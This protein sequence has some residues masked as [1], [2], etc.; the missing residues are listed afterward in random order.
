MA[1][2]FRQ[3]YDIDSGTYTYLLADEATGE[4]AIIDPVYERHERDLALIHELQ[5]KLRWSIETHCHADHVT[6]A[7]VISSRTGCKT[8][9]SVASE[10]RGLDHSLQHEDTLDFGS[11]TLEIRATPGH[12]AGCISLI[13]R[14]PNMVFTGDALLIRG[15]GRTD[16]QQ[17]SAEL[18][19]DSICNQLFSLPD[20]TTV[21]PGHDYAGRTSSTIGE[22]RRLNPRIGGGA[23][24]TDFI[25]YLNNMRLPHPRNMDIAVP[26]NLNLGMPDEMPRTPGWAPVTTTYAGVLEVPAQWVAAHLDE[27][28][29]LDVRTVIETD[30]EPTRIA[31]ACM[32]PL[33]ELRDR[34]GELPD[35]GR[36]VMTICRSGRRSVM[37]AEI[38]RGHGRDKVANVKG[39]LLAWY[40]EGLPVERA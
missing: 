1:T 23:N 18:L 12:T 13:H 40:A 2:L 15:C 30:E 8:A 35:D 36:P 11:V 24:K 25:H 6:A 28:H 22:E 34:L 20:D 3:L 39:G 26:A 5:L 37:A 31:T 27:V 38:L 29:L 10:I 19:F 4:A 32:I 33:N 9:A 16:F 17:G 7:Y 14:D 21:W